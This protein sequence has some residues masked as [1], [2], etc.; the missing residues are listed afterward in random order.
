MY[1]SHAESGAQDTETT[2][3]V[4]AEILPKDVNTTYAEILPRYTDPS[5]SETKNSAATVTVTQEGTSSDT[6]HQQ[7][8]K[9]FISRYIDQVSQVLDSVDMNIED[10]THYI[11]CNVCIES[12]SR[13]VTG[14]SYLYS[15]SSLSVSVTI[16]TTD[17]K[18][19]LGT[20]CVAKYS[21][22]GLADHV[23][24]NSYF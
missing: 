3:A 12:W 17:S 22:K 18:W 13:V 19:V 5:Y 20:E 10:R 9:I 16:P 21:F 1:V 11:K 6:Q 4:Y 15:Y 14:V 23:R 24:H 7:R 2:T 8:H